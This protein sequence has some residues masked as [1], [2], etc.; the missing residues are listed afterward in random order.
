MSA[1][2]GIGEYWSYAQLLDVPGHDPVRFRVYVWKH[3]RIQLGQMGETHRVTELMSHGVNA[4][5]TVARIN[6]QINGIQSIF[7]LDVKAQFSVLSRHMAKYIHNKI[8]LGK[9][10][11]K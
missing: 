1:L 5:R 2:L 6:A 9:Q 8:R 4:A 10:G 3:Q 11:G 7:G